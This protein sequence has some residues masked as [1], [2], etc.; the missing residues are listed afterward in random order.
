MISTHLKK[1][2]PQIGS[3]SQFKGCKFQ[4]YV[5]PLKVNHRFK[6]GGSFWKMINPTKIMVVRKPTFKNGGQGLPGKPSPRSYGFYAVKIPSLFP[7]LRPPWR[8]SPSDLRWQNVSPSVSWPRN[9]RRQF[10][11]QQQHQPFRGI[12]SGKLHS[13]KLT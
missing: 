7:T 2:D 10:F 4:K 8:W 6:N 5:K 9:S 11:V 12:P 3:F 13:P 1:Y